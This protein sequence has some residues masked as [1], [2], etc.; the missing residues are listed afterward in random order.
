MV[1]YGSI[2]KQAEAIYDEACINKTSA[3][4]V[5]SSI[6]PYG[7]QTRLDSVYVVFPRFVL[8]E[9][10]RHRLYSLTDGDY[11]GDYECSWR[12][13]SLSDRS[14]RAVPPEKLIPEI[15]TG[16]GLA[17]PA[18]FRARSKG[19]GG[20]EDLTGDDLVEAR[21]RWI[22][23]ALIACD[24]AEEALLWEEKGTANRRLDPYIYTH[25]LQT[26]T[27]DGWMNFFGLRL[28][29]GADTSIQLLAGECWKAYQG[30]QPE[31]LKPGEWHLPFIDGTDYPFV[32]AYLGF[33]GEEYDNTPPILLSGVLNCIKALSAA[34]CAHLS[35]NDLETSQRMTIE[36]GVSIYDRLINSVPVHASPAEHQ[37]W[38]DGYNDLTGL[39]H[40]PE[41]SG[42][43]CPGWVQARKMLPGEAVAPLPKG[44]A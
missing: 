4:I 5:R 41:A 35:W 20:G 34:R 15:R 21:L 17:M 1:V 13:F 38:V 6:T 23:H 3:Q 31:L 36:R 16:K 2:A 43:F 19:M 24:M 22:R 39:F 18:K 30:A 10:N 14:S 26:A 8:A 9:R 29:E 7:E 42:N 40:H 25:S 32:R 12:S 37:A 27:R 28:D 33:G 11:D 44:Y